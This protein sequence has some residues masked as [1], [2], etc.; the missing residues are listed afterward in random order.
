MLC[1]LHF[2]KDLRENHNINSLI[3]NNC[4]QDHVENFFS[5]I[6][7]GG[8]NSS[9]IANGISKSYG[10]LVLYSRGSNCNIY[11]GEFLIKL[12]QLQTIPN[13]PKPI[14]FYPEIIPFT[15]FLITN[16]LYN[17]IVLIALDIRNYIHKYCYTK[18][19]DLIC[20]SATTYFYSD[21]LLI[22]N[23]SKNVYNRF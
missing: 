10:R 11:S 22:M 16:L 7:P 3:T 8:L 20:M 17:S 14:I 15:T 5:R 23:K 9:R 1:L 18:C 4:S 13:T 6:A 19:V 12:L 21:H 2:S